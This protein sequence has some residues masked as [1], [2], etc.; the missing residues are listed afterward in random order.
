MA[1]A[2]ILAAA[3]RAVQKYSMAL[4]SQMAMA[5]ACSQMIDPKSLKLFVRAVELGKIAAAAECEHIA[6]AAI[7]KRIA[8]LELALGTAL[9][10][11]SN[12]GV[13]PTPAGKALANLSHRVLNDL[14]ALRAQVREFALGGHGQVRVLAN[15]SAI[16][17]FLPHDFSRLLAR[18][19]HIEVRLEEK[20]SSDVAWGVIQNEADVG[21]L[22]LGDVPDELEMHTYRE[23]E[24]VAVVP[25]GHPLARRRSVTFAE[26]LS[27]DYVGLHSGSQLNLQM[28]KA[29]SQMNRT[30]RCRVQV[31]SYDAL[32][33]MIKAGLG[34]GL[35]PKGLAHSYSKALSLKTLT[36]QEPWAQRTL[37]VCFRSYGGLSPASRLLVD[38]L[39]RKHGE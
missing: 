5:G 2:V 32:C 3:L 34:I 38:T 20:V 22:I 28:L 30:W 23:D 17:Q 35:M 39:L 37:A 33:Q 18:H 12:K 21:V 4:P 26:T 7:S 36:L 14:E 29:A 1:W 19:P 16:T 25:V 8:D 27:Y 15:I 6:T 31:K 11:R 10:E 24:L 13:V 9:V